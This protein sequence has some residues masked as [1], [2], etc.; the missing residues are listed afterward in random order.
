MSEVSESYH[1][2]T[3]DPAEGVELLRRV[4]LHGF[5][6]PP[7][8]GWTTILVEGPPFVANGLLAAHTAGVLLHYMY[9]EDDC[10]TFDLYEGKE[11]VCGYYPDCE[12]TSEPPF[13]HDF[14]IETAVRLLGLSPEQTPQLEEILLPSCGDD[15]D[16]DARVEAFA[17]LIHL[18]NYR[19]INYLDFVHLYDEDDEEDKHIV[20]L[21]PQRTALSEYALPAANDR[22]TTDRELFFPRILYGDARTVRKQWKRV[23]RAARKSGSWT[24]AFSSLE[25]T[26]INRLGG[27]V[28]LS[29]GRPFLSASEPVWRLYNVGW[30]LYA[31]HGKDNVDRKV[32]ESEYH[33]LILTGAESF[34]FAVALLAYGPDAP[35]PAPL[36][37]VPYRETRSAFLARFVRWL[38]EII[39]LGPR[40]NC[41]H[42]SVHPPWDPPSWAFRIESIAYDLGWKCG[43]EQLK[44]QYY[45]NFVESMCDEGIIAREGER[46]RVTTQP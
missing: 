18:N 39:A 22:F 17:K 25:F 45:G 13:P 44:T 14:H 15:I 16:M 30:D 5:V 35:F 11:C 38:P 6:F 10:L 7:S 40:L 4:G 37:D 3:N 1:L 2:R 34:W 32:R 26:S 43:V 8:D 12:D 9:A 27:D 42:Y 41:G 28:Y 31:F 23:V 24:E 33:H 19:W 46:F 20:E 21:T 29:D 36:A